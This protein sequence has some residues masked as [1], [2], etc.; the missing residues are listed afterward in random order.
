VYKKLSGGIS[1]LK[2][3]IPNFAIG[4]SVCGQ[5]IV[6][7]K[8][9]SGRPKIILQC[10]IHA[11]EYITS[12]MAL[13]HISFLSD[14]RLKGTIYYIPCTNPDGVRLC[15]DG[16]KS[17]PK[18]YRNFLVKI[19]KGTDFRLF[20]ANIN[21][22][23]LNTNF[24]AKWAQGEQNIGRAAPANFVG[25]H[26]NSE[27]ETQALIKFTNQIKPDL[28]LSYHSKGEVIYY[29]FDKKIDNLCR[30]LCRRQNRHSKEQ[31][32]L[33]TIH[34]IT[35]YKLI[36]T[37]NSTGGYKDWCLFRKNIQSYTIEVGEDILSHPIP[38]E[39]LNGIYDKNKYLPLALLGVLL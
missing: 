34:K 11:R 35:G 31:E 4:K 9:G 13:R 5:E 19:N 39:E 29:G 38:L 7:F 36:K 20:K 10:A 37:K 27:P 24:D 1:R 25:R 17:T 30:F 6:C 28:T 26:P 32:Y 8:L 3:T 33:D 18:K 12:F 23:D 14:F 22:V 15:L 2:K 21:G 16:I